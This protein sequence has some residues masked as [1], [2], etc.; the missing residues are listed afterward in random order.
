MWPTEPGLG[1]I[2]CNGDWAC[3]NVIF[4]YPAPNTDYSVTCS[5]G[6]CTEATIYC[7]NSARCDIDMERAMALQFIVQTLHDVILI[8]METMR[9]SL[10]HLRGQRNQVLAVYHVMVIGRATMLSFLILLQIQII[11]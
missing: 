10:H 11:L 9:V 5:Y 8:V 6:A 7:P 3:Y 2:S 1:S 4:P